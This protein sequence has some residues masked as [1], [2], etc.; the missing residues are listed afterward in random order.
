MEDGVEVGLIMG[1]M[2]EGL[3]AIGLV[4]SCKVTHLFRK[5]R[6]IFTVLLMA[7]EL[8]CESIQ[9]HNLLLVYGIWEFSH[10]F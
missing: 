9:D 7:H 2:G 8:I 5:K 4:N 10:L 1:G 6:R 3:G